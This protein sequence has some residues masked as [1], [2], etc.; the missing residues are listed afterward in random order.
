[1]SKIKVGDFVK[2]SHEKN[3]NRNQPPELIEHNKVYQVVR[4]NRTVKGQT[5][6][7]IVDENSKR[8]LRTYSDKIFEVVIVEPPRYFYNGVIYKKIFSNDKIVV[9]ENVEDGSVISV[10]PSERISLIENV[11]KRIEKFIDLTER[12]SISHTDKTL[13]VNMFKSI[14]KELQSR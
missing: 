13:M 8:V 14:V 10:L 6:L 11:E 2:Y 1:M 4:V 12:L 3:P 9:L 7:T 5:R